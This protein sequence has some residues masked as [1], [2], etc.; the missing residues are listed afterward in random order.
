MHLICF[1]CIYNLFYFLWTPQKD[2]W[3]LTHTQFGI[4][5]LFVYIICIYLY[6]A[7]IFVSTNLNFRCSNQ[8][9]CCCSNCYFQFCLT[10]STSFVFYLWSEQSQWS[11]KCKGI[12]VRTIPYCPSATGETKLPPP[13]L[14]SLKM[15]LQTES[16]WD[17]TDVGITERLV[18]TVSVH[19]TLP[20]SVGSYTVKVLQDSSISSP[21]RKLLTVT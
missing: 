1:L 13:H 21:E 8:L 15:R 19:F 3:S 9:V 2:I 10:S 18:K 12:Y 6:F 16:C 17:G 4:M 11:M 20:T 7:C 14:F 5:F